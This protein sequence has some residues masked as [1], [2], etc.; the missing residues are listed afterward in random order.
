MASAAAPRRVD[1]AST[2]QPGRRAAAARRRRGPPSTR[3]SGA[4]RTGAQ[5]HLDKTVPRRSVSALEAVRMK[6]PA[7][8]R[9]RAATSSAGLQRRSKAAARRQCQRYQTRTE[10]GHGAGICACSW[11]LFKKKS[12]ATPRAAC[13]RSC[14]ARLSR[15]MSCARS[16]AWRAARP[17]PLTS[18]SPPFT[19][20]YRRGPFWPAYGAIARPPDPSE[21]PACDGPTAAPPQRPSSDGSR[22]GPT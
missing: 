15:A 3:Q 2:A 18:P 12:A 9:T 11:P 6:A 16:A 19:Q 1:G 22:R 17:P 7:R 13:L 10:T 20:C 8:F 14:P 21:S 4:P 5:L